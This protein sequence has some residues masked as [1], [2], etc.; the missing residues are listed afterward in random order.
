MVNGNQYHSKCS[1]QHIK[2]GCIDNWS[3][4][5]CGILFG[6]LFYTLVPNELVPYISK[7]FTLIISNKNIKLHSDIP[8]LT[9]EADY[10]HA[11]VCL[12]FGMFVEHRLIEL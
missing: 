5:I 11:L 7:N 8:R 4:R 2:F 9:D 10:E 3:T 6:S 1:K 12:E